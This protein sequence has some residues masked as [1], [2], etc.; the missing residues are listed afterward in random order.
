[1]PTINNIYKTIF[2][3][4][5]KINVYV[6]FLNHP[7]VHFCPTVVR[8][9]ARASYAHGQATRTGKLRARASYA[10]GQTTRTDK[11]RARASYAHGQT[12]STDKLRAR[13]SYAHGQATHT[14]K[15]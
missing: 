14:G 2:L 11:L 4:T 9:C 3:F 1:M 6:F 13:A 12:T 10:H 5:K 8:K 15:R 7:T